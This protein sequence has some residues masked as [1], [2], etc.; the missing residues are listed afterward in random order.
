MG[1]LQA[2]LK[3]YHFGPLI[4]LA[5]TVAIFIRTKKVKV[6]RR[7][8]LQDG[9]QLGDSVVT[10]SGIIGKIVDKNAKVIAI[11]TSPNIIIKI[12]K[13]FIETLTEI[14]D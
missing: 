14:N 2:M 9:L 11:E 10:S 12:D 6:A 3:P 5:F 1:F 8:K 7:K 4:M 13:S